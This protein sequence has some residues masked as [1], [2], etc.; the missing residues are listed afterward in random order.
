M[1]EHSR[2]TGVNQDRTVRELAR[3][4]YVNIADLINFEDCTLKPDV[5]PD[6]LAAVA[7]Y[8]VK[9]TPTPHGNIIEREIRLFD[10]IRA[11]ELLGKHLGM[12]KDT[13]SIDTTV[14]IIDDIGADGDEEEAAG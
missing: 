6:D 10:K 2:R 9:V 5:S 7:S 8:K 11:L 14:Q 1:A 3:L 4:S 12:F 13:L